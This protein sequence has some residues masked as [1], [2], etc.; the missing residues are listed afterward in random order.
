MLWGGLV[1]EIS[2]WTRG[3]VLSKGWNLGYQHN[4]TVSITCLLDDH[5]S[6]DDLYHYTSV[7]VNLYSIGL[8]RFQSTFD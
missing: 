3:C 4:K 8:Y 1:S 2:V 6:L 5:S 7:V